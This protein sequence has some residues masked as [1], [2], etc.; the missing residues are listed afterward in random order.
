MIKDKEPVVD[1]QVRGSAE[2][3]QPV[4]TNAQ[5]ATKELVLVRSHSRLPCLATCHPAGIAWNALFPMLDGIERYT[6]V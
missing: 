1:V 2:V 4:Y 5:E 6:R 3:R